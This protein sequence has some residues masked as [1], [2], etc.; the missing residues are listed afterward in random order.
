MQRTQEKLL[1]FSFIATRKNLHRNVEQSN[2]CLRFLVNSHASPFMFCSICCCFRRGSQFVSSIWMLYMALL[3]NEYGWL[4]LIKWI[5]C[6]EDGRWPYRM[7]ESYFIQKL[8]NR[9]DGLR[10]LVHTTHKHFRKSL[11][12]VRCSLTLIWTSD[13]GNVIIGLLIS[14]VRESSDIYVQ[15]IVISWP[16]LNLLAIRSK[17]CSWRT[18][19]TRSELHA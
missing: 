1:H 10:S 15:N 19:M 16:I 6:Y 7:R 5:L 4:Q 8:Q 14:V 12:H 13:L 11:S 17:T 3:C 18:S 9:K 2:C